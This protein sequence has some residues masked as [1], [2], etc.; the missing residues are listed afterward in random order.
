MPLT[1]RGIRI[2]ISEDMAHKG[3]ST[4]SPTMT[5]KYLFPTWDH[6]RP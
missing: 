5:E 1:G 2:H 6:S 4:I 3:A